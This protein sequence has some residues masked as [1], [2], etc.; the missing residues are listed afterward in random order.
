MEGSE[1][2]AAAAYSVC[3]LAPYAGVVAALERWDAAA[4]AGLMLAA[5]VR[6]CEG[7]PLR[8]ESAL[9]RAAAVAS[10][11]ERPYVADLLAA[12][13]V[14]RGMFTRAAAAL[15][16]GA[17]AP[18][19]LESGS[20]ALASVIHAAT[21]AAR[22]ADDEASAARAALADVCSDAVRLRVHQR[23]ALSA[24]YRGRGAAALDEVHRGLRIAQRLGAQRPAAALHALAY[25]VHAALTGDDDAAWRDALALERAAEAGGEAPCRALARVAIYEL[26]AERGD[27]DRL[28]AARTALHAEALPE[29]YHERFGT[30]VADALRLASGDELEA[31]RN[32]LLV[33]KDTTGRT[34]GER[35]LCRALLA[36]IGVA[37]GDDD[38]ARRFSRQARAVAAH[39]A[40]R[41]AA[42]ELRY[43][44]LA[45]ALGAVAGRL[46]GD[47]LRRSGAELRF[48]RRDPRLA[49]LLGVRSCD[50]L[51][52]VPAA[53]RG[54]ARLIALAAERV[55]RRPSS[56][57][58][59]ETETEI[60]RLVACGRNAPQIAEI[61]NRSPHTVRTHLRNARAKLDAHGRLE[62][63]DRAR[64][65]GVLGR[66]SA[67]AP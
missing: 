31:S 23:L 22:L 7:D 3:A 9:R 57:P 46:A 41:A 27:A 36:L 38:A 60:V 40:H 44:G 26:A 65:L 42:H 52:H 11:T 17:P 64:M 24:Y 59:T 54:Y 49:A 51:A 47:A 13:L 1:A 66:S 67:N 25:A 10:R 45:R 39:P 32:A 12:L 21:G 50:D 19:E 16:D 48:L 61:M 2:A 5:T 37:L 28:A 15:A 43:R 14:S 55:A 63:V 29:Q 4:T 8:A 62:L 20:L 33:L 35:A 6:Q 53:V 30:G 56:G 18:R 34:H 58:L